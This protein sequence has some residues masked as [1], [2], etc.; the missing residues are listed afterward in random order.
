V[1]LRASDGSLLGSELLIATG[2]GAT[3]VFVPGMITT[4]AGDGQWIYRGD[5]G[6]AT[7]SPLF[8]PMGG[9]A[10]AA[11]TCFCPT[12]TTSGSAE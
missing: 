2:V 4:V 9:A 12:P 3:G 11:G 10:D 1:L 6:L 8:L 7:Q 5:G